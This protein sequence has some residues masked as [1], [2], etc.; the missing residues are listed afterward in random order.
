ME[1]SSFFFKQRF[2]SSSSSPSSSRGFSFSPEK[3]FQNLR[4][5]GGLVTENA[6][7]WTSLTEGPL[8]HSLT[9]GKLASTY[10]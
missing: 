5:Q 2:F 4:F 7:T 6:F 9:H 3:F 8:I 1:F 10:S